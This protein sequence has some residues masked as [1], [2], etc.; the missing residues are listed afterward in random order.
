MMRRPLTTLTLLAVCVLLAL[1][2][3]AVVAGTS[4]GGTSASRAAAA[5]ATRSWRL[6]LSPDPD[7]LAL[8]QIS[9]RK[10]ARRPLSARALQLVVS[11]PFGDDYAAIA[12]LR[13]VGS[14][15]PTALVLLV[16]RPS[17]LMDPV[18]VHLRVTARS[19][20]GA[21]TVLTLT[22]PFTR[23]AAAPRAA[24]CDLR[25]KGAA[26]TGSE[27][28]GLGAHGAPLAGFSA[29]SAVAQAYDVA[30]GRPYASSFRQAIEPS[31]P[32]PVSPAPPQPAP[33]S[34]VEPSPGPPVGKLP[35]EGCQPS[36]GRACPVAV[37]SARRAA[38]LDGAQR[39]AAGAH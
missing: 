16:D 35:G 5:A 31:S 38:A 3:I 24:L 32:A 7:D 23:R 19:S 17:P 9:F 21:A 37:R 29:V 6:N 30:W 4:V 11:G 8:A 20:L 12:A 15:G 10:A 36:P 2:G 18:T 1:A 39:S 33:P 34:P 27:L 14:R 25:R 22:D 13:A 28:S 26:L